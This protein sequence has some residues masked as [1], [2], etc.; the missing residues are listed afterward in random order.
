MMHYKRKWPISWPE[1]NPVLLL[2]LE[3]DASPSQGYCQQ[4]VSG[5][6][7]STSRVKRDNVEQSFLSRE[8]TQQ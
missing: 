7:L 4:H 8:I 5:T 2:H 1:L 6:H 3:S